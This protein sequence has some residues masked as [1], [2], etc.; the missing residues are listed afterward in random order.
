LGGF[1]RANVDLSG[2]AFAEPGRQDE[3]TLSSA[4]P[5]PDEPENEAEA[6]PVGSR[7][8]ICLEGFFE[9]SVMKQLKGL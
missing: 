9:G 8:Q 6:L 4:R 7:K 2:L 1:Q 5:H 3:Q